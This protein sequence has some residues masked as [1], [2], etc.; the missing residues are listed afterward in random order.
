[1]IPYF[2][3]G[4]KNYP[5]IEEVLFWERDTTDNIID[6]MNVNIPRSNIFILFCSEQALSSEIV[7]LEWKTALSLK[8]KIIPIFEDVNYIPPILRSILGVAYQSNI[9]DTL[10]LTYETI[11]KKLKQPLEYE[12]LLTPSQIAQNVQNIHE[13][14]Q[15]KLN[16]SGISRDL[17]MRILAYP[18]L[19]KENFIVMDQISELKRNL[20]RNVSRGLMIDSI[21][22]A[23]IF[24]QLE[25]DQN[26]F[27]SISNREYV[28]SIII[29]KNGFI[30]YNLHYNK[31]NTTQR[32]LLQT[33]YMAA[34]FLGFLELLL[35]FFNEIKYEGDIKLIFNVYN[36]HEW[37]Y[38]P[39][40][41]W[42]PYEDKQFNNAELTQIE[43]IFPIKYLEKV[44]NKFTIVQDI[45]S[46]MILGYG[47]TAGY[48][49]P[50][51]YKKQ[52]K[53]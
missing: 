27:Y 14:L 4:L 7:E 10:R 13:E 24:N 35:F 26:G 22:P 52:Y 48:K 34:Y 32:E 42:L 46:E 28:G 19:P 51:D 30:I 25:V 49:I 11:R 36:I 53:R 47:E 40:P 5:D 16:T 21:S 29:R 23:V 17:E 43:I 15:N 20:E 41:K 37:S 18:I 8:K 31:D 3:D 1:M 38:S 2:A 45:F 12:N 50:D 44:E 39:Y 6:Y 9:D 33:Y